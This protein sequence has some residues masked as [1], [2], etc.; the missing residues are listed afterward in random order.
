MQISSHGNIPIQIGIKCKSVQSINYYTNPID[1][2][3]SLMILED[4]MSSLMEDCVYSVTSD[5]Y[6]T[7]T[8]HTRDENATTPNTARFTQGN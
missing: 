7:L 2:T 5:Q 1:D 4:T 3:F 6:K 8:F